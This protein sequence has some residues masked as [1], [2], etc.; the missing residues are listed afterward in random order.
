M[1]SSP[2]EG[3]AASKESSDEQKAKF[4]K[5]LLGLLDRPLYALLL[6]RKQDRLAYETRLA[7]RVKGKFGSMAVITGVFA[8]I[9]KL[10]FW[11]QIDLASKD[12]IENETKKIRKSIHEKGSVE[13]EDIT[14]TI[15]LVAHL[16]GSL[17]VGKSVH[18]IRMMFKKT[19]DEKKIAQTETES[20]DFLRREKESL[21]HVYYSWGFYPGVAA[22]LKLTGD[23][24]EDR[25]I[26]DRNERQLEKTVL[27]GKKEDVLV[28]IRENI[29]AGTASA[30]EKLYYL[31]QTN[32]KR[33]HWFASIPAF[34]E[35][36]ADYAGIDIPQEIIDK[37]S[38][39]S[40]RVKMKRTGYT[41]KQK[42]D[43]H[44]QGFKISDDTLEQDVTIEDIK[45]GDAYLELAIL[46][47]FPDVAVRDAQGNS[48]VDRKKLEEKLGIPTLPERFIEFM[49]EHD[50][51]YQG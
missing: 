5:E 47:L 24:K 16:L 1:K 34:L 6:T 32:K 36:F 30:K 39:L 46:R 14:A 31:L 3:S 26:I 25:K 45:E 8:E 41:Q 50:P 48:R 11:P 40:L 2:Q 28:R 9:E 19:P 38:A 17:Y 42:E 15:S 12:L 21:Y 35:L 13:Q 49:K 43:A 29:G 7:A 22:R 44:R 27:K 4:A 20:E 51:T 23:K 33:G 37:A 10:L 18:E